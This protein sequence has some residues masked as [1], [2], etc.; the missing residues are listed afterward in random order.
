MAAKSA[1]LANQFEA[2]IQE[3]MTT[4]EK[5]SEADW[6]K[7]TE[8]ETWSVGV[9]AHH[10]ASALEPV[11]HMIEGLVAGQAPGTRTGA[12]I[13]EMNARHARDYAHCTKPETIELLQKGAAVAV[14]VIRQLSDDQLEKSGTVLADAPPMTAEQLITAGLLARTDQ[15]FGSIQKTVGHVEVKRQ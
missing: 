13:A 7:V 10:L 6:T 15:H 11:A 14:A 4:L 5:L 9:T 2:K 3:A 12:T 8:V 1:G